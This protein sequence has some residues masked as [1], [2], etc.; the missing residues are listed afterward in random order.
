M[1]RFKEY[2]NYKEISKILE[3]HTKYNTFS[4]FETNIKSL[5][6]E[7]IQSKINKKEGLF[8]NDIQ[9]IPE[10]EIIKEN[11]KHYTKFVIVNEKINNLIKKFKIEYKLKNNYSDKKYSFCF[12]P[13]FYYGTNFIEIG[14]FNIEEM[15]DSNYYIYTF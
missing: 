4:D 15:F 5:K 10:E 13:Q 2:F 12:Y 9:I 14:S 11:I 7:I 3:K 1:K 6:D 8:N